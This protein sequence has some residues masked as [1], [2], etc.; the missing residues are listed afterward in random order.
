MGGVL[1]II[2]ETGKLFPRH[3]DAQFA[4]TARFDA[5]QTEIGYNEPLS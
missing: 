3:A 5:A 2:G 1:Q 4:R